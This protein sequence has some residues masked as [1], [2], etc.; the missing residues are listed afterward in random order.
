MYIDMSD[1]FYGAWWGAFLGDALAMPTHGYSSQKMLQKD[2]GEVADFMPAKPQHPESILHSIQVPD[3]PP[4]YDYLG[5]ARRT[6]WKQYGIHPH[7]NFEAGRNTLPMFLSLHLAAAITDPSTEFHFDT[8]MQRYHAVMVAPDGHPDTFISSVHRQYF[9]NLA[10]GK[11]VKKN[12]CPDAHIGDIVIFLPLI[13]EGISS[14]P[15]AHRR[16][17]KAL[18]YFCTG[19]TAPNSAYFVSEIISMLVRGAT[20]EDVLYTIMTPDR[21]FCL[22][23]PYRRWIKNREEES[24]INMMGRFARLEE[25]LPLSIYLSL[26]YAGNIRQ[27]LL[28]NANLG[29]ETCGRGALIGMLMGAQCGFKNLPRDMVSKL[30][31]SGEIQALGKLMHDAVM[32][33]KVS[34]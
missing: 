20:L 14:L 32:N 13:L 29:G 16:I 7:H 15:D 34:G 1:R 10:E 31:Y 19:E 5:E 12:G 6:L 24:A 18:E 33:V 30:V 4:Q 25:A 8:W 26:K 23:Y 3:L 27:A 2:Y 22:A 17:F 28:V 11:D 21:H 9:E